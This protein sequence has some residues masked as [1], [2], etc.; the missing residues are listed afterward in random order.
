MKNYIR[1]IKLILPH[2]G[3]FIIA[4][5]CM[6]LTSLF[7]A[8]PLA[9]IIPLVDK[10]ITG[11]NITLPPGVVSPEWLVNIVNT[12][13]T[14]SP[15]RL[16]NI[17]TLMI[18]VIF[19]LKGLFEFLKQYYMS[20]VSQ[21]VIRD[22]KN[23][24]YKKLQDLSMDFYSHNPTGEL[25]SRITYDAAV[26]RDAIGSGV[27]DSFS[28]PIELVFYI[29]ALIGLTVYGGIPWKLM[30][31]SFIVFPLILYP[32][33]RIGKRLRKISRT[34]QEK[35]G[36]INN[37]LYETISAIKLVKSFCMQ[38]Y[39]WKRFKEHNQNFYKLDMKSIL[40]MKIVSPLT[41]LMAI[42]CVAAILWIAGKS[43]VTGELSAGVFTAFLAAIFSMVKP[44][45]KLS[46]VYGITQ[47]AMA[48]ADRIFHLL[49]TPVTIREKENPKKIDSFTSN[50]TFENVSFKYDKEAILEDINLTINKG[51]IV[52]LVGPS[53]GGKSTLVN[54]IPRFY[55]PGKGTVRIDGTDIRDVSI[56]S[57]REKIGLVTQE[58]LL[59]NDSVKTNI[60]YGHEDI[61]EE[62]LI[63]VAKA[64]NAHR[65]IKDFPQGYDT[66]IGERGLKIS[67]GQ[68]QRI[69]I[70][71]A[72]YKNPPI[73]IFDEAT[74]QLDT[75]SEK[76]VQEAI[77]NLMKGRTVIV[78]AH[79]LSTITHADRIV[80]IDRGKIT[81]S[82]KHEE[83]LTRSP[84][85]KKLYEMQFAV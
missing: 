76:L 16:L 57:L 33:V 60:S 45:K 22:I 37:M 10:V 53:G 67:G 70:A 1:F 84:L 74:S 24:I 42:V 61:N 5:A 51:E 35:I 44:V 56:T 40:R 73:L 69:A 14:M 49:D 43:I 58:T 26:I 11:K 21:R 29:A 31:M 79:R 9:L 30:I 18:V 12:I 32:V 47:H 64:A 59:F 36:D 82:G 81:D 75:E 19:L 50:I 28:Q 7:S 72:V 62:Q 20:D 23:T 4:V 3:V 55:D 85:Y 78:I 8:S 2:S 38:D 80:V 68:R 6:F 66:I 13:N 41:E 15:L 34:S 54:L 77:N 25:M 71:R 65:F 83:L 52:A 46:N 39:E 27:A 63:K 48:A 17:M